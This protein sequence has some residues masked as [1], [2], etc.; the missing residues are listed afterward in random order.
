MVLQDKN[1]LMPR[2]TAEVRIAVPP[3]YSDQLLFMSHDYCQPIAGL[4]LKV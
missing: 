3:Y 1:L 2:G 4:Q